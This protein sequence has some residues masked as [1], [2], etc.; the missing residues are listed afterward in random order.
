MT[1]LA[2]QNWAAWPFPACF[3]SGTQEPDEVIVGWRR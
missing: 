3:A 2:E 1:T